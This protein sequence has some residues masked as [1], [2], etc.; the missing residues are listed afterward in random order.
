MYKKYIK[1]F[2]DFTIALFAL[3]LLIIPLMILAVI[4]KIK[5]GSPIL[6]FS[7]RIGKDEKPFTMFKFRSMTNEKS[8]NGEL[9]PDTERITKLG[10]FL[11]SSSIDELPELINVIKGDMSFI[12]PRPLPVSYLPYFKNEERIRHT[13]RGG[14]SGLAQVNG[15]NSLGWDEKFAYDIQYAKNIT[16][17]NDMLIFAKTLQRVFKRNDIGLRGTCGFED[18]NVSREQEFLSDEV[19]IKL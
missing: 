12:G 6:Y 15:R 17:K 3:V 2:L 4:I 5:I 1:R 14:I 18:L 10:R 8:D 9:L 11:R 13:I 16:F 7:I 19:E